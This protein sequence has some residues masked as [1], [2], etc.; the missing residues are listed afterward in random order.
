MSLEDDLIWLMSICKKP[1]SLKYLEPSAHV[2]SILSLM[3]GTSYTDEEIAK[4]SMVGIVATTARLNNE[5]RFHTLD[6]RSFLQVAN[7]LL[8]EEDD[9][10]NYNKLVAKIQGETSINMEQEGQSDVK[11]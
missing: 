7:I 3:Q 4:L 5:E 9:G 2:I 6:P 1:S 11:E 8:D 10:K